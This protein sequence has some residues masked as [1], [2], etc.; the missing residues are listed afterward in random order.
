RTVTADF[1]ELVVVEPSP[2][3]RGVVEVETERFDQVQTR[4]GVGAEPDDVAG[5]GRNF[6]LKK[7]DMEHPGIMPGS[8]PS[9]GPADPDPPASARNATTKRATTADRTPRCWRRPAGRPSAHCAAAWSPRPTERRT[10]ARS[11]PR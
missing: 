11:G 8:Y 2:A 5:V 6:R 9:A 4:A 10:A 3:Q 7:D 1:G